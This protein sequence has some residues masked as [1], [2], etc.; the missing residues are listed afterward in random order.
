MFIFEVP[1][2]EVSAADTQQRIAAIKSTQVDSALEI[3][4]IEA[5]LI[6]SA[7][8]LSLLEDSLADTTTTLSHLETAL[9]DPALHLLV[10]E[11]AST[12]TRVAIT[13]QEVFLVDTRLVNPATLFV[14]ALGS[15][16]FPW[17][18]QRP[19]RRLI[20]RAQLRDRDSAAA[21]YVYGKSLTDRADLQLVF[22]RVDT[23]TLQ[24]LLIWVRTTVR[25]TA[26]T[27][28]WIDHNK[29]QHSARLR[30][31]RISHRQ[32]GPDR[33]LVEIDLQEDLP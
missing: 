5:A 15:V 2:G 9:I 16:L 31:P 21:S 3:S 22:P 10:L 33:H 11:T 4:R 24:I 32:T 20:S 29:T 26:E 12:D 7:S 27:F 19:Q 30:T 18:P 25:G 23:A 8:L 28:N 13:A 6:D 14:H 1:G 17:A